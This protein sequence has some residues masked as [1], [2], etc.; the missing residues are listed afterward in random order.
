LPVNPGYIEDSYQLI[1]Q[2][3]APLLCDGVIPILMG[4]DHSITLP[5][6][7]AVTKITG[8]AALVQF[9]SHLDTG[10][11]YFGRRYNHGT[12]F[13]RTVEKG[14]ILILMHP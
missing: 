9:D 14:L 3:L 13:R 12:V 1:E 4:G 5:E 8:P 6:L 10:D 11:Q 2:A 7:R